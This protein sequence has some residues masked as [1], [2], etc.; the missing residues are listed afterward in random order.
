M[1]IFTK[2]ATRFKMRDQSLLPKKWW[3]HFEVEITLLLSGPSGTAFEIL[4]SLQT[5]NPTVQ[6]KSS[7]HQNFTPEILVH[8]WSYVLKMTSSKF[9]I[10]QK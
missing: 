6:A 3:G 2:K 8:Y 7:V 5:K 4:K 1:G 9:T 10:V